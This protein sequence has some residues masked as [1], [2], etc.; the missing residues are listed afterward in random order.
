MRGSILIVSYWIHLVASVIWIGGIAFV[1]F[2]AIPKAKQVLGAEASKLMVE[3]GKRF[4]L[5]VN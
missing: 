2:I 5:L 3:F 1:L 4:T